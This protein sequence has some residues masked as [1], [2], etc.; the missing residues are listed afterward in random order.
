MITGRACP[1]G[2]PPVVTGGLGADVLVGL[3]EGLAIA[4]PGVLLLALAWLL[5]GRRGVFP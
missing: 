1:C 2:H 3:L 4:G 5:R